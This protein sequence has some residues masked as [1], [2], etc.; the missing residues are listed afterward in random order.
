MNPSQAPTLAQLRM[1]APMRAIIVPG[2]V[3]FK[4]RVGQKRTVVDVCLISNIHHGQAIGR[5]LYKVPLLYTKIN[6]ENGEE[7]TPEEG[8]MV[9]VSFV[10]GNLNDPIVIG[11]IAPPDSTILAKDDEAPRYHRHR[12]GTDEVIDK[13]GNLDTY[14]NGNESRE[15]KDDLTT[16]IGGNESRDVGGNRV[17]VIEGNESLTVNSGNVTI[18]VSGGNA[19]VSINGKTSWSSSGIDLDGGG[20]SVKG[21]VQGNCIC[22]YTGRPHGMVSGTVKASM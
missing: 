3:N 20:G 7:W 9:L 21:V 16:E 8:D 4:D 2:G 17:T 14:V 6:R 15:I 22:A 11:Y 19:T 13:D 18:N 5:T 1:Y 10:D 12:S